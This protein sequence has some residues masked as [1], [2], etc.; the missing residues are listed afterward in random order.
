VVLGGQ[1]VL[2][3]FTDNLKGRRADES[4]TFTVNYPEDFNAKGLAGKTI[5]YTA[6]VSSVRR[7]EVPALDDEWVQTLGEEEIDSVEKLRARV[8]ENLT[9]HAAHESESRVRDEVL[10]RLLEAHQFEVPETLV[11]YQANQLLQSTLRDMMRRGIDPRTPEFDWDAMREMVRRRADDDLRGSLLLERVAEAEGLDVTD[12]EVE[13]E[14]D[15]LV[16]QSGQSHEQVRAALTKEGG[17]RSIHDRLRNRKALDFLVEHA[18]VTTEEWREEQE[19]EEAP[20][21]AEEGSA[22]REASGQE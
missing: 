16:E 15:A 14:I 5:E 9:K 3:E 21:E 8:E 4:V 1:G 10:S 7:K 11:S 6:N 2:Q 18:A 12:E 19:P 22:A 17:E 13:A 20:R